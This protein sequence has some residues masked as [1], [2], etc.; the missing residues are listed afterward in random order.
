MAVKTAKKEYRCRI[1][2]QSITQKQNKGSDNIPMCADCM[3][4]HSFIRCCHCGEPRGSIDIQYAPD[5]KEKN[6][7]FCKYCV[8]DYALLH[9]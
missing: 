2:H 9:E 1:C 5:D 7:P 3:R 6:Y 8:N 4:I